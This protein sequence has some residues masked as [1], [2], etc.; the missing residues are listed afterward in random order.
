M[1]T[2][3]LITEGVT[4]QVVIENILIG[5]FGEDVFVH[6]LQP[7]Y[8]E[9]D[10]SRIEAFGGWQSVFRYCESCLLYTSDA[11]DE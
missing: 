6:P 1:S 8:D 5:M 7:I 10:S 3:A 9:T 4:D 2:F 11:A